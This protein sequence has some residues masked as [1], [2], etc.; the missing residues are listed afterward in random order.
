MLK[1]RHALSRRTLLQAGSIAIGLPFLE[2]MT[3][4]SVFGAP[5]DPAP[6]MISLMYGL[7]SPYF[8]L[9]RG[10]EGPLRYYQPFVEGGKVAMFTDVDMK[11]AAPNP[12]DAQH[13]YGQPYLFSGHRTLLATGNNVIPQGPSL[14][15]EVMSHNYPDGMPTPFRVIDTGIYFRRG[16]NYQYQRVF[17]REGRNA[18]DF[19]DLASPI[20]F[21]E[22][23]FGTVPGA[24]QMTGKERAERSVIDYVIPAYE[25]Y[26]KGSGALPAADVAVLNN[27]LERLRQIERNVYT[28]PEVMPVVNV[29]RP[30]PPDLDYKV[31]GGND[32]Q[33]ELVH[34]VSPSDFETAYQILADL[35]VAGLQMDSFRFGNL[36]FDS[37]GG[38]TYFVGPYAHPDDAAYQFNG[39]PHYDYHRLAVDDPEAVKVGTA[40]NY[41]IH[42]N[43]AK[44]L[45]KLDNQE[46]LTPSGL[47]LLQQACVMIGS[48]VGTNHDVSRVGH[49]FAGGAGRFKLGQHVTEQ[50]KAIELYNAIGKS[51]GLTSVGDGVDYVQDAAII[52]ADG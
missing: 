37:G 30:N 33:P 29:E 16:L 51:Y 15:F 38:H 36:S 34:H 13:H 6:S 32:S 50:V 14:H 28:T 41:F 42:S 46:F 26:T 17:D 21:F 7:G 10:F 9:D 20:D 39:N 11:A 31:D 18:A 12:V 25:K 43:I 3:R 52:L 45:E 47:T 27:H 1:Y 24:A 4:R 44:V 49:L 5:E 8:V 40:H 23:L 22:K 48:E 19:E 2:S 35:F